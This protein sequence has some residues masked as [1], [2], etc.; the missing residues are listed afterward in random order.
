MQLGFES[1]TGLGLFV[2]ADSDVGD[3]LH[4]WGSL[5]GGRVAV[6]IV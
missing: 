3:G 2:S 4:G 1:G 5:C 6:A